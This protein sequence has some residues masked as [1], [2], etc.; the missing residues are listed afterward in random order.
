MVRLEML[1]IPRLLL[2]CLVFTFQYGQIRNGVGTVSGGGGGRF[3]F[4][5]GQIRNFI[6]RFDTDEE[7]KIYIPVWLDQKFTTGLPNQ[8]L[9]ENLHSSMVRLEISTLSIICIFSTIFT[10]QYGQIRNQCYNR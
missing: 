2:Y 5:Y 6:K 3:T 8:Q 9:G 4:Q 1:L 7:L 10:F